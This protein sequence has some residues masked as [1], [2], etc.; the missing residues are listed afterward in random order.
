M[1]PQPDKNALVW[2]DRDIHQKVK[3]AATVEGITIKRFIEQI[4][5]AEARA[6]IAA[7]RDE[8]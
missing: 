6:I 8:V 5:D 1:P 2:I 7:F 4:I 3:L